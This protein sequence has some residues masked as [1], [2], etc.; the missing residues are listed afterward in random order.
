MCLTWTSET[1]NP[2]VK[3]FRGQ[4]RQRVA[5]T[6]CGFGS[7]RRRQELEGSKINAL[8]CGQKKKKKSRQRKKWADNIAELSRESFTTTRALAHDCQRWKQLVQHGRSVCVHTCHH[9]L[10]IRVLTTVGMFGVYRKCI[11]SS[12]RQLVQHLTAQC[13]PQADL[14]S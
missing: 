2:P 12:L 10:V 3:T 6:C 4:H 5:V 1:N 7:V 11:L 14:Y 9:C 13:P 8:P